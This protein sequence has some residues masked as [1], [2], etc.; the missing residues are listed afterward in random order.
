MCKLIFCRR[1]ANS[2][3]TVTPSVK[4]MDCLHWWYNHAAHLVSSSTAMGFLKK[5]EKH[6]C[7]S[8][9]AI[10]ERNWWKTVG[11]EEKLGTISR[12]K[13]GEPSVIYVGYPQ[14]KFW[15]AIKEKQEYITNQ[16]YCHL[17]YIPYTTFWHIFQHSWGTCYSVAPVFVSPHRTM[18]PP[19]MQSMW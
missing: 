13:K 15:W 12:L 7:T 6:T 10:Q 2:D 16:V 19:V 9:T 14:S 4:C 17:M 5:S 18:P 8:P 1:L 3:I 11:T